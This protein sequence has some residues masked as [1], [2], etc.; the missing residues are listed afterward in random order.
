MAFSWSTK[1]STNSGNFTNLIKIT[2]NTN[3]NYENLNLHRQT[4]QISPRHSVTVQFLLL[5]THSL[6]VLVQF[7]YEIN[8]IPLKVSVLLLTVQNFFQWIWLRNMFITAL[9]WAAL[10]RFV[11]HLKA[12][13]RPF[14]DLW[15]HSRFSKT[16]PGGL[17]E[18]LWGRA[19]SFNWVCKK[20][21]CVES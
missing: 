16:F 18:L 14:S 8:F 13:P 15:A 12:Q 2:L 19:F 17:V 5:G 9:N 11:P 10:R 4:I 6:K 7:F 3:S 1:I 20:P 21:L